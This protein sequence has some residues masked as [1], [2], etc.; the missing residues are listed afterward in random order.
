MKYGNYNFIG[1]YDLTGVPVGGEFP[2]TE[3]SKELYEK[4]KSAQSG[5]LLVILGET[6]AYANFIYN[7]FGDGNTYAYTVALV[8]GNTPVP[9]VMVLDPDGTYTAFGLN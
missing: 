3:V 2:A 9:I 5:T 6:R 7:L 4:A 1:S 8:E